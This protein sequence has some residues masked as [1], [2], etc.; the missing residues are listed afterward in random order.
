M[1]TLELRVLRQSEN[2]LKIARHLQ[3]HDKIEQVFYPGLQQHDNHVVAAKQM[4][5]FGGMVS[6]DLGEFEHG[7]E[8]MNALDL[9]AIATSL[10]GVESIAQHSASMTHATLTPE[11]RTAAGI[12]EGLIRFS[13][14]IEA[15]EDIISDVEAALESI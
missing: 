3:A 12:S 2:A 5:G 6:F 8:F 11:E 9:V 13:T 10:G 1:K 4:R 15:K 7:R 14:G